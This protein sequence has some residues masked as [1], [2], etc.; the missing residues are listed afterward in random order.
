MVHKELR[1]LPKTINEREIQ[2]SVTSPLVAVADDD[3]SVQ[4]TLSDDSDVSDTTDA[5]SSVDESAFHEV[6]Y[7]CS[8]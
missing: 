6:A 2:W 3:S 8:T 5:E 1:F 7:A 4:D